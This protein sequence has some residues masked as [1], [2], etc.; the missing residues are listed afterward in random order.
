MLIKNNPT[1][2]QLHD[3]W[4]QRIV[5]KFR[6]IDFSNCSDFLCLI[7]YLDNSPQ[8]FYSEKAFN[9]YYD[10]L[11]NI[12]T[13][14]PK[15]LAEIIKDAEQILSI[16]N[17]ILT[18]VNNKH[19][20]DILLPKEHNDLINFIDKE[21]HYNLLKVYETPFFQFCQII[22]KYYW[23]KA[24]KGTDGLDLYNSVEQLKKEGFNFIDS[25]Y[26]HDV[27]N[28]IA[29]GKVIFSDLDIT[30]IDKKNNKAKIPTRKII[31]TLDGTLDVV[32][33]FCLAFKVFCLTNSDYFEKYKIPIPQS[34]LLEEL[35]AK[36]NAPAWKITNCLESVAMHDKRQLMIYIQN[37]NWDFSK[38]NWYCFTTAYWAESLT[39]CYDRIFFSFNSKHAKLSPSGWA[40]YD[41]GKLKELREHNE[42][43]LEEYK[44]VLEGDLLFFI[45]KI[46]FPRFVYKIGSIVSIMKVALP[47][48]WTNYKNT[49]FPKLFIVRE[50][51]IH[52][53]A[54]YSI[55]NDP[56]VIINSQFYDNI[57][58]LIRNNK[59]KIIRKA[60]KY[61]RNQC[62]RFSL[63]RYLP[64]KYI[65]LFIYDSDKRVRNLRNSGLISEL[66]ATIE[67]NTSKQIRTI[68]IIGGRVEQIGKYRIVWNKKWI[69]KRAAANKRS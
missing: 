33:G 65:R 68:D 55:I 64:V 50:T 1:T 42:T 2:A 17:R 61:S 53:R 63:T 36:A 66:I 11:S 15:I 37:D 59:K 7:S 19:I 4:R 26:L 47:L 39:K 18:E 31:D 45:P 46:K 3:D 32:N 20:H 35:Q 12:K 38:V 21:I 57:E 6:N 56:S 24:K 28:G 52:S 40:A 10:S 49:Y 62:S 58:Q 9:Q 27:R 67:I 44:G 13:N 14:D 51:Q 8:K 43:R 34:I 60:I 41:A 16:S 23:I 29:H 22:A 25:I 30:Y 54:G 69:E 48:A 5:N